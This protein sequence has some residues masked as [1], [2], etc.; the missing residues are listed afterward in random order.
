MICFYSDDIFLGYAHTNE[1]SKFNFKLE[2]P[3]DI[4]LDNEIFA[5]YGGDVAFD[6]DDIPY[7]EDS[8]DENSKFEECKS[9]IIYK[10]INIIL[11]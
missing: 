1:F 4:K 9:K 8:Y 6:L 3:K 10:V 11:N 2:L 7:R 5:Y